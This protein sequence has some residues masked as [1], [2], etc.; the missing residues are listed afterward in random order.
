MNTPMATDPPKRTDESTPV[1]TPERAEELVREG[2]TAA[3]DY[4]QRVEEM[5][6]I[7]KDAR[8]TRAR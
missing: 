4:R 8:Q 5:W 3:R 7:S 1:I 2:E 6:T